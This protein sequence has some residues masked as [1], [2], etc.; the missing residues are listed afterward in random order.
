[1]R[2]AMI[3]QTLLTPAVA[4]TRGA[5]VTAAA[6]AGVGATAAGVTGAGA[7]ETSAASTA[8]PGP[9]PRT[10]RRSTPRSAASRRALGDAAAMRAGAAEPLPAR[11]RS[12]YASTS[13]FSMRPLA[14]LMAARSTPCCSAIRRASGD[15]F[16]PAAV[17]AAAADVTA[18]DAAAAE[19]VDDAAAD[20]APATAGAGDA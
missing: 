4:A 8:P 12:R 15:A 2:S 11:V 16:T 3:R 9:E 5:V 19:T 14:V 17:D 6:A 1:M 20:I 13:A 7:P 18:A 10:A